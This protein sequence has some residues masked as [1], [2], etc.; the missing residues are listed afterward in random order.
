VYGIKSRVKDFHSDEDE[1]NKLYNE[2]LKLVRDL[3]ENP[4]ICKIFHD[5][6]KD[7]LALHLYAH[8]CPVNFFDTS[9]VHLLIKQLDKVVEQFFVRMELEELRVKKQQPQPEESKGTGDEEEKKLD[10]S[11]PSQV[12]KVD[13]KKKKE[14]KA[15]GMDI[16]DFANIVIKPDVDEELVNDMTRALEQFGPPGLNKVLI[17]YQASHG[18]NALKD[19]FK[20]RFDS[21]PREYFLKRPMDQEWIVYSAKD[22]EDLI[23]VKEKMIEKLHI[24]LEEIFGEFDLEKTRM[25]AHK[26]SKTYATYGCYTSKK[27]PEKR[28]H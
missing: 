1:I 21:Y 23:E 5:G 17:G 3:M 22:V 4:K 12:Q 10:E 13:S 2:T 28:I 16:E 9:A 8:A 24:K 25:V 27:E 15:K 19:I 7:S 20:Q 14:K 6:R 18:D 26:A 11:A